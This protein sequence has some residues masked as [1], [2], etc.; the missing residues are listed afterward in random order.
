MLSLIFTLAPYASGIDFGIFKIPD[1]SEKSKK[2]L[3]YVGPCFLL[4]TLACF[5]PLWPPLMLPLTFELTNNTEN[6]ISIH[7]WCEID[8]FEPDRGGGIKVSYPSYSRELEPINNSSKTPFIIPAGKN[9]IFQT[10]LPIK[11]AVKNLYERCTGTIEV[12]F[13]DHKRKYIEGAAWKLTSRL[14][15]V[16]KLGVNLH[17]PRY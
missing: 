9:K 14:K 1:L 6:D 7:P 11:G 8:I 3:K 17:G 13:Y 15:D 5:L 10:M 2:I 12:S 16:S 4:L